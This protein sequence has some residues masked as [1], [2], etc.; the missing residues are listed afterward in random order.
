MHAALALTR[1]NT[2]GSAL[3]IINTGTRG[4][5]RKHLSYQRPNE[6]SRLPG[7]YYPL[8]NVRKRQVDLQS[9]RYQ[10]TGVSSS[11]H[12]GLFSSHLTRRV[13]QAAQPPRLLV[14]DRLLLRLA[15]SS[16]SAD[17]S[18]SPELD[19]MNS[20]HSGSDFSIC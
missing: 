13:L 5:S 16:S 10:K 14:C 18:R 4:I 19:M 15:A 8:R 12:K 9:L 7:A 3:Y 17:T 11:Y 20:F 6:A 2:V 1:R